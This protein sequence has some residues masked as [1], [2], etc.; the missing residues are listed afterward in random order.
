MI[1]CPPRIICTVIFPGESGILSLDT[2]DPTENEPEDPPQL[3]TTVAGAVAYTAA[4]IVSY[5]SSELRC[6]KRK[7][8][9]GTYSSPV[10]TCWLR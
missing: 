8:R 5:A 7:Y 2:P 4:H 9:E 6:H 10:P 3:R 1:V